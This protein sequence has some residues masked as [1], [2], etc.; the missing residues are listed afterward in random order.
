M[1]K[2]KFGKFELGLMLAALVLIIF[3]VGR[4]FI[5]SLYLSYRFTPDESVATYD[6]LKKSL[7]IALDTRQLQVRG[8]AYILA[9]GPMVEWATPSGPPMYLFA[10]DGRLLDFTPDVGEDRRF[11]EKWIF[12]SDYYNQKS[13]R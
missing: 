4:A 2:F 7:G 6:Q 11:N 9:I 10:I 5:S 8:M 3:V 13:V 1:G 12:G